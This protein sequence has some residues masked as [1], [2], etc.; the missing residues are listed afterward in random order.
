MS[1]KENIIEAIKKLGNPKDGVGVELK[2]EF[3][4]E[5]LD[6]VVLYLVDQFKNCVH[7]DYSHH[8][9]Y[10]R[11]YKYTPFDVDGAINK[12]VGLPSEE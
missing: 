9:V 5:Q 12:L 11:K 6:G 4:N 1:E 3:T 8:Y 10:Y 2:W 7:K